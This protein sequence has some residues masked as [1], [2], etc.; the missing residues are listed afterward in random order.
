MVGTP[1]HERGVEHRI[2]GR[3]ISYGDWYVLDGRFEVAPAPVA[4]QLPHFFGIR[5]NTFCRPGHGPYRE[6]IFALVVRI[7]EN[8]LTGHK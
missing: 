8:K 3:V 7:K 5:S 4:V 2:F 6:E 1:Q